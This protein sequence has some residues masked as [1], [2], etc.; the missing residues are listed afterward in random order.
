MVSSAT[1]RRT[2]AADVDRLRHEVHAAM[3]WSCTHP[4]QLCVSLRVERNGLHRELATR[5]PIARSV[6]LAKLVLRPFVV[7]QPPALMLHGRAAKTARAEAVPAK[8]RPTELH[9]DRAPEAA[10]QTPEPFERTVVAAI[11]AHRTR[12]AVET[13]DPS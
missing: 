12:A 8:T 3:P 13:T 1:R 6:R 5:F 4:A 7:H 2:P 9:L 10:G 11:T